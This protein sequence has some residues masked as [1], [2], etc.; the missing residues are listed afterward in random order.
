[1][2]KSKLTKIDQKLLYVKYC[3]KDLERKKAKS[4]DVETIQFFSKKITRL[5]NMIEKK[6]IKVK[7]YS[8]FLQAND[9]NYV[10]DF[11]E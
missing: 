11:K 10:K 2:L 5:E 1:M 8:D 7:K 6:L 3:I 9:P 4:K